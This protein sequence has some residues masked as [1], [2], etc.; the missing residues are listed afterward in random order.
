MSDIFNE[1]SEEVRREQF[2]KLWEKHGFLMLGAAFLV[3]AGVGGWRGYE[4]YQ[5]RKAAEAGAAFQAA[6]TLSDQDKS[7]EAQA[8]FAR[9]R[10]G[11]FAVLSDA[12]ALREASEL[13]KR[14]PQ[15]AAKLYDSAC[16]R[17]D[18]R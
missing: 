4:W 16:G 1:V 12:G 14:D 11:E 9:D 17:Y 3:V 5:T 13:A 18:G 2:K 10:H 7:A 15:A 8:S 6:V